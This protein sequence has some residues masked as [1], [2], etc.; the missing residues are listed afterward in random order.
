MTKKLNKKVV[1]NG[2][3]IQIFER[4]NKVENYVRVLGHVNVPAHLSFESGMTLGDAIFKVEGAKDS[5]YDFIHIYRYVSQTDRKLLRKRVNDNSFKL[6]AQDIIVVYSDDDL[7]EKDSIEI[8]GEV[9]DPGKYVYFKEMTLFDAIILAKLKTFASESQ[10]EVSRFS[11]DFSSVL[12]FSLTEAKNVSLKPGDKINI[13]YDNLKDQTISIELIGEFVFPGKYT[14][15]KGT[16]LADV[17]QKAGGYT[18]S[19]YLKAA[20][21]SRQSVKEYD[22]L[23]QEKVIEDE[24]RRLIYDQSHLGSLSTDSQISFGVMMTARQ[25]ALKFLERKSKSTEGRVVIDLYREDFIQSEDNFKVQDGDRLEVPTRPESVHLIGGVQQGVSMAYNPSF[26]TYDYI[27]NVGGFTKYADKSNIYVFKTSG[28]VFQN[29]SNIEPGDI[30][31][32]P[33]KVHISFNW[34]QFL[35]NITS[36]VSNAVTSIALVRSLQ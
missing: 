23:G 1:Q 33:E 2:D 11:G 32:V 6:K 3:V 7:K 27:S 29:Y 35:T 22:E 26:N 28:R 13:K 34:L 10:I 17:I 24:K 25:E 20:I 9:I 8:S 31:Y 30:I 21:F 12:Y 16:K 18:N 36:I 5:A 4:S 19:A 15:N 14:V